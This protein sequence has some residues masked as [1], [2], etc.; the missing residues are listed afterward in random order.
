MLHGNATGGLRWEFRQG[1]SILRDG[2]TRLLD[3]RH[4]K[5]GIARVVS[6]TERWLVYHQGFWRPRL[7]LARNG[8]SIVVIDDYCPGNISRVEVPGGRTYALQVKHNPTVRVSLLSANGN[9]VL[10]Y[11]QTPAKPKPRATFHVSDRSIPNEDLLVLAVLGCH[12]FLSFREELSTASVK[13]K[14]L[15]VAAE[16]DSIE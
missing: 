12:A 15:T 10:H 5:R 7:V 9:E 8:R 4:N 16:H 14:R 3:M 11:S 1:L 6:G 13:P 2:D